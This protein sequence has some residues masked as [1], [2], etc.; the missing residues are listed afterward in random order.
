MGE[1]RLGKW[2]VSAS[3]NEWCVCMFGALFGFSFQVSLFFFHRTMSDPFKSPINC[4]SVCPRLIDYLCIVGSRNYV[5]INSSHAASVQTPELLRRYPPSDHKVRNNGGKTWKLTKIGSLR[6]ENLCTFRFA[7]SLSR[8]RVFNLRQFCRGR[9]SVN[10][11][12]K[13]TCSSCW[14]STTLKI[15]TLRTTVHELDFVRNFT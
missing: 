14:C 7:W 12:S 3:Q 10:K 1:G 8:E 2:P 11:F 15:I 4:K 6:P 13:C 5:G 9:S